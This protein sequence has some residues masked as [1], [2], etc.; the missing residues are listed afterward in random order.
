MREPTLIAAYRRLWRH[1]DWR[2]RFALL[3]DDIELT[4]GALADRVESLA[5]ALVAR[6]VAPGDIVALSMARTGDS[7]TVLLAI[8]FA[9]G[10]VCPLEPRLAPDEV[11]DRLGRIRCRWAIT[12]NGLAPQFAETT[13]VTV[14]ER[15]ALTSGGEASS[16]N[17]TPD[18]PALTLFTSGST[19]RPKAVQLNHRAIANN[20]RGLV[21]HTK[22]T[23]ADRMLHVMPIY[24]TNGINN[25]IFAPLLAG[26]QIAFAPRF[27]APDMPE[28]MARYQPTMLAG[29]PTMYS[30]M[31]AHEFPEA[32]R[33]NL[34]MLRCGSAPITP[35]LHERIE[36]AF[37][38]PVVVSY[39]LSEATCTSTM[40]PPDDRRVGSVGTVLANQTVALLDPERDERVPEGAQGEIAIAGG[41]L[42]SGY[43]DDDGRP[44]PQSVSS[45]WLRSGDLGRFDEDGY[46]FITGRIKD[47]IIRGGE[48]IPPGVIEDVVSANPAIEA[49]CVVGRPDVD[50]GEVPIAYVVAAAGQTIDEAA[51]MQEVEIR[52]SRIYRPEAVIC[53]DSLPENAVGKVDRKALDR[54]AAGAQHSTAVG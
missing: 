33:A 31:L 30:R 17:V 34:R 42:M 5:R 40:N 36:M 18:T 26:S 3:S 13:G 21:E 53:L 10:S 48:N 51:L 27:R 46:L 15:A 45:G 9:G 24:H 4:Y 14:I 2:D 20:A 52:L 1:E 6:G 37:G 44:D 38:C 22:L 39:G 47:V 49:C 41:S 19:G 32:A 16:V 28:L 25:Q 12:D 29:V 8:L 35:D 43:L 50:L 54:R 11:A 7:V 23:F